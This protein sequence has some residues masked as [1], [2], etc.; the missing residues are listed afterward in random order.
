MFIVSVT[1]I[2]SP[3]CWGVLIPPPNLIR[4]LNIGKF[5]VFI[6]FLASLKHILLESIEKQTKTI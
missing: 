4:P 3:T 6:A 5:Y 1:L 2:F